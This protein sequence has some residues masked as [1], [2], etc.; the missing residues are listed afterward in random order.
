M[1]NKLTQPI[2]RT[3]H[4]GARRL[5]AAFV[6][7]LLLILLVVQT[8]LAVN[9]PPVQIYYI[10]LPENQIYSA[11]KSIYPSRNI[12]TPSN[13]V[14]SPIR[15]YV[16]IS[17][18]G[19]GTIVY[20]DHWEDGFEVDI[21]QP[22]QATT[23]I[24]GDAN[25]ANG[26][27]PGF[28][29][30]LLDPDSV[31]IL[32]NLV[33]INNMA[34]IDF[35]GGDKIGASRPI[36]M[37]RAHWSDNTATLLA[38][39]VEIYDT[40]AWGTF[41]RAPVGENVVYN[42]I[43]EYAGLAVMAA[44]DGTVVNIDTD[45][46]GTVDVTVT[47]D[48]GE[49]HLVDGDILAGAS[50]SA[51]QPVQTVL[52]T[53][54]VCETYE[55]RWYG[56][57]PVDTWGNDYYSP[58]NSYIATIGTT[59]FLYNPHATALAVSWE[60]TAGAQ[61]VVN[62][63]ANGVGTA[64][65][66][67]TAS[68]AHFFTADQRPF[69]AVGAYGS[70]N[71]NT[72]ANSR[73]D[74][75][76]ALLPETQLTY[77]TIIGWG[78]GRDPTSAVNPGENGSP[79]WVMPVPPNGSNAAIEI[80]VDYDGDGA[81]A[82]TDSFGF[83]YDTLLTLNPLQ[84]AKV[85]DPDGDQSALVLYVCDGSAA[86]LAAAW[87][88]DAATASPAEPGLDLGTTAPPA[89]TFVAGKSA[90]LVGDA[91]GNGLAEPGDSIRYDVIVRNASRVPLGSV[92]VSDTV[93]VHTTY[94]LNSASFNNGASTA[95][96]ADGVLTPFPLDEGGVDLGAMPVRGVYTVTF[97]VRINNPLP[98][99]VTLV[100]NR[101]FVTV[102]GETVEPEVDTP[103]NRTAG[104]VIKKFTN[105]VDADSPTGPL[106]TAGGPVTWTYI[107]TNTGDLSLPTVTVT[108]NVAGVTPVR[109]GGDGNSN[110]ILDAGE[111]WLY[112]ATGIAISGQYA[113]IGT[114]TAIPTGR[115]AVGDND[116]S[117]YFGGT[118]AIAVAKTAS[119]ALVR[120]G[121]PVSYTY[122]VSNTGNLPL[123]NVTVSDDKCAAVT[124]VQ[125]G[126]FNIGDVNA[127]NLLDVAEQ[128]RFTCVTPLAVDTRN[129][130]T[131]TGQDPISRTVT[132][133]DTATVDV[134]NPAIQL[135]KS[136]IP[137]TVGVGGVVTY[138]FVITNIGD[139]PLVTVTLSDDLCSPL[140]YLDG[141]NP[142]D[143]VMAP[144][145]AWRYQ[146]SRAL[147]IDTTNV[148][149]VTAVDL[150][151][152]PVN[153]TDDAFVNVLAPAIAL[154]KTPSATAVISGTPVLYTFVVTNVGESVL[155]TVQLTD[156]KCSPLSFAGGDPQSDNLLNPGEVW[157]YLCT[158]VIYSDTLNVATV[159]GIDPFGTVVSDTA[160]A[161]VDVPIIYFPIIMV[162]PKECPP[163]DGCPLPVNELKGLA[164]HDGSKQLFVTSRADDRL[165]RVDL[166]DFETFTDTT[167]GDQPWGVA[168][169]PAANRVYVASYGSGD[170]Q[171]YDTVTMQRL[172][173]IPVGGEP[174]LIKALPALDTV[175]VLV[176]ATSE[177]AIIQGTTLVQKISAGGSGPFGLAIDP[178]NNY[179]YV[180]NRDSA[181]FATL[182]QEG[183]QWQFKSNVV[184][185]DGRQLFGIDYDPTTNLL[186][187]IYTFKNGDGSWYLDVWKPSLTQQWGKERTVTLYEVGSSSLPNIGGVG[188]V[189]SP[190]THNVYVANTLVGTVTI[191]DG[192]TG[193]RKE[194]IATAGDPFAIVRSEAGVIYIG[195][196]GPGR[197]IT[198]QDE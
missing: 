43:N 119:A 162:P 76:F 64:V 36:A 74:W 72:G 99:N 133:T 171:V 151:G 144:G 146:C 29:G 100:T 167:T 22:K 108:D 7:A 137:T 142:V 101:A 39:S 160:E 166:T 131:T 2:V 42:S 127:N 164:V 123:A 179:V 16:S 10:P 83:H 109:I 90:T 183:G 174:S 192:L 190:A 193:N 168:V 130:A 141:D 195:L 196:R 96:I 46:N 107:V 88:Q 122:V 1:L 194:N 44:E 27:P 11:L 150:L 184:L 180:A 198:L 25:P 140:H 113:N 156:N 106:I 40:T 13:D 52:I 65:M 135:D 95:T 78:P 45:G 8:V 148:A 51:S 138:S 118:P 35:D 77:Q 60:T 120:P 188:I 153:D 158:S 154:S 161:F 182:Y 85:F 117:H 157:T 18:I 62:V 23:Q 87:G 69:Y 59:V 94:V 9:P 50:V 47:L 6:S 132:A 4:T 79:V 112:Q 92:R 19:A 14:T 66:P 104:V 105:G 121:T 48:Q 139:S 20:Y 57:A 31:I 128:W 145:E 15:A 54:D 114:V 172:A 70:T 163:P 185:E 173:T 53:G 68:G 189:V 82:L 197:V 21:S 181:H 165:V 86:Q 24:W 17:I 61:A 81:G 169:L 175:F 56:L 28:A 191:I 49:S 3:V 124:P 26:A 37:S 55:S 186:Y 110:N 103:I 5:P 176:R 12:C 187:S 116:P 32:T 80:C 73:A 149:T 125:S 84:N 30:D 93:P 129:V 89:S 41:F 177:V 75:G 97:S 33:D 58:V 115:P 126:V 159:S 34:A 102:D 136:V 178:V 147:Q 143:G 170:V 63:P 98:D 111:V 71:P 67:T 134:I 152:G 38:G 91:N 155:A